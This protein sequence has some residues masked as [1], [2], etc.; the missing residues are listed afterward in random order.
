[1]IEA[2]KNYPLVKKVRKTGWY[3]RFRQSLPG[4]PQLVVDDSATVENA[5]FVRLEW[6]AN[7]RK[8]AFGVVQDAERFPRWTKFCR[9]LRNNGFSYSI[10]NVHSHDWLENASRYDAIVGLCSC[11]PWH[12]QELRQ[13]YY[14][15]ERYLGV[16]TY[17]STEE[18]L[19]YENKRLEAYIAEAAGIPFAKT[20]VSHDR[21]DATALVKNLRYPI[22][23][24]VVPSSGSVGVQLLRDSRD[25]TRI[26]ES[27]FSSN[28][29]KT[30]VHYF[31]QKNCVYFQEY[32]PNDGYDLRVM[33]VG[34]LLFGYYRK[35]PPGDFRA[36]GMGLVEKRALPEKAM[37]LALALN[38]TVRSP[39]LVVDFVHA[40]TGQYYVVEFS[41]VCQMETPEQLH[42]DG[43][44]GAYVWTEDQGFR[45]QPCRYWLPELA[46]KGF[47]LRTWPGGEETAD[48]VGFRGE[49]QQSPRF[50]PG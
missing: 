34:N 49:P 42:V 43:V 14:F 25:A 28:G 11:E 21:E 26:I 12:L 24:K 38:R 5:D 39:M 13:K 32:I 16:R 15:L 27:V 23:S 9:F 6:P 50:F 47:I 36:S 7:L 35:V 44:P 46:L 37:E 20:F 10:Y 2:L 1:M 3:Y 18:V 4:R 33:V 8:P 29:R 30:H 45:F 31:R 17:P 40:L 41:P 19:L 22:V 48:R